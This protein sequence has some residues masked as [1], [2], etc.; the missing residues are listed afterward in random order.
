MVILNVIW[1]YSFGMI[2]L[3]AP[4]PWDSQE[5]LSPHSYRTETNDNI[6][7]LCLTRYFFVFSAPSEELFKGKKI[8]TKE[9]RENRI[10][11]GRR[12]D[13][14]MFWFKSENEFPVYFPLLSFKPSYYSFGRIAVAWKKKCWFY[15]HVFYVN[16]SVFEGGLD[17]WAGTKQG[18]WA[19]LLGGSVV[20]QNSFLD[21]QLSSAQGHSKDTYQGVRPKPSR[22]TGTAQKNKQ[23]LQSQI[24]SVGMM[25]FA[26]FGSVF[27]WYH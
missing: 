24:P 26:Y 10:T 22:D 6:A 1:L 15:R 25:N 2:G 5:R 20:I 7:P 19:G 27:F 12:M 3:H 11:R 16:P 8:N 13:S 17:R 14:I 18:C 4:L 23:F 9:Y 21:Q